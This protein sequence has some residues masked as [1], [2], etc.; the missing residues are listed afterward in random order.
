MKPFL[1]GAIF[2]VMALIAFSEVT[3]N[4]GGQ[5]PLQ[6]AVNDLFTGIRLR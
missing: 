6:R 1:A 5:L 4:V 3:P 2:V